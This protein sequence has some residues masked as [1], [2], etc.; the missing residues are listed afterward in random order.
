MGRGLLK[1]STSTETP[2]LFGDGVG[3]VHQRTVGGEI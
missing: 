1:K 3:K 2:G